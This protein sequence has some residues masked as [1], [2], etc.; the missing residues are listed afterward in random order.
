MKSQ[1]FFTALLKASR[2]SVRRW[3]SLGSLFQIGGLATEKAWW[4]VATLWASRWVATQSESAIDALVSW[5]STDCSWDMH[6]VSIQVSGHEGFCKP[7]PTLF[8]R[9][10]ATSARGPELGVM[11]SNLPE[12][13]TNLATTFCTN[14]LHH[15]LHP[16]KGQGKSHV[17]CC[18]NLSLVWPARAPLFS[19]SLHQGMGES[20][21]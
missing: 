4:H 10:Q 15:I 11:Q 14:I 3:I 1:G 20:G 21:W 12:T 13:N 6:S 17:E 8:E 19:G 7:K 5:T 9:Q 18:N 2:D 16:N